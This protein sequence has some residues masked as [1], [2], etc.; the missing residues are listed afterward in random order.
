MT[1]SDRSLRLAV[2]LELESK[3]DSKRSATDEN[4]S[5]AF[6]VEDRRMPLPLS[7]VP[8]MTASDEEGASDIDGARHIDMGIE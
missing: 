3:K 5:M 7:P 1:V 6:V 2:L 4:V 8:T